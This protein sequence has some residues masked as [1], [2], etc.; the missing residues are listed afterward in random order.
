MELASNP[1]PHDASGSR[2]VHFLHVGKTGGTAIKHALVKAP[3][4]QGRE[5]IFHGHDI[6][7]DEIDPAESVVF[8]LREPVSRFVSAFYSRLRCGQP[9]YYF[10][11]TD[12]EQR[13][14]SAFPTPEALAMSLA[15]SSAIHH[16]LAQEALEGIRHFRRLNRWLIGEDEL[17]ARRSQILFIAFQESLAHDFEILRRLLDLPSSVVLP[18]GEVEAHRSPAGLSKQIGP[19]GLE[20]LSRWYSE[21]TRLIEICRQLM[22]LRSYQVIP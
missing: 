6:S 2:R 5:L 21:D 22:E 20:A 11:W 17:L 7:L 18:T 3:E 14:F 8:S 15:D 9:R 1:W 10:P 12:L 13:V 4:T 19:P 16:T